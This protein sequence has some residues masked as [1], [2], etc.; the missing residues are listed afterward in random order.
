[1]NVLFDAAKEALD[2]LTAHGF[3]ACIIGGLAVQ[4][5]GEPR[6]TQDVDLTVLAEFGREGPVVDA[7]LQAFTARRDDAR[8]FAARYRVLL[9]QTSNGVGLDIALGA[10]PFEIEAVERS[11]PYRFAP[12]CVVATCSAEDLI[13][14]KLVAGRPRDVADIQGIVSRQFGK[15]DIA[16]IRHWGSL[17]AEAKEDPDLIAPFEAALVAAGAAK[18]KR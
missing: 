2:H 3:R 13:I 9:L 8:E 6:L 1:M 17:F 5:W 4:R 12:G 16:R 11:T 14:H 7:C 18:R 10:I 15:L